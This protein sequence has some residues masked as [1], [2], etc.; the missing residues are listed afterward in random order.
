M[1]HFLLRPSL[2]IVGALAAGC[3]LA[4]RQMLMPEELAAAPDW[5]VEGWNDWTFD[6]RLRFG[7][8]EVRDIA[9][10]GA[11]PRGGVLDA[12]IGDEE[13]QYRFS[14]R[15][16]D[17]TTGTDL[18]LVDCDNRDAERTRPLP[19]SSGVAVDAS[20]SLYCTLE[21]LAEPGDLWSLHVGAVSPQLPSGFL[22]RGESQFSIVA[23]ERARGGQ[24]GSFAGYLLTRTGE[25]VGAVETI[26]RGRVRLR[27]D[28]VGGER[29]LLA[30]AAAALL[31]H[32]KLLN[33][34]A[35]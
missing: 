34:S 15:V 21:P 23:G 14:F 25:R 12:L 5:P 16:R 11:Y 22:V 30:G 19:R 8:Y 1:E 31:L 7:N 10:T 35:S 28:L 17:R 27:P 3:S 2:L 29:D 24:S 6:E 32:D 13:S 4:P 20:R 26:T 9:R 33:R 18:W